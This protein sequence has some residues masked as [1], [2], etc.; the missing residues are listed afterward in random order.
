M[1]VTEIGEFTRQVTLSPVP[2]SLHY[3]SQSSRTAITYRK[4]IHGS[5][6]NN[7]E[8]SS[9]PRQKYV[10]AFSELKLHVTINQGNLEDCC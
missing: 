4:H 6:P 5:Q 1:N 2:P 10:Q 3:F 7:A 9:D 8:P